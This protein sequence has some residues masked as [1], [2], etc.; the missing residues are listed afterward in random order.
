M[1][2]RILHSRQGPETRAAA[3]RTINWHAINHDP[4][5]FEHPEIFDVE[6]FRRN[7]ELASQH[8]AFGNGEHFCIG[9]HMSRLEIQ[10]MLEE[11]V[12]RLRNPAFAQPV[13]FVR[14]YFVN[15]IKSMR[16]TFDAEG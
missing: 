10:V 15:G 11:L 3:F 16:L 5:V 12:P 14:D 1:T 8:R 13:E 4:A 7:P 9:A 6:R 2:Q